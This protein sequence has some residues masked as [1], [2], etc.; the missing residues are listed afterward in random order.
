[1]WLSWQDQAACSHECSSCQYVS[2]LQLHAQLLTLLALPP[3]PP[4]RCSHVIWQTPRLTWPL[5]A[6]PWATTRCMTWWRWTAAQQVGGRMVDE[7]RCC[8]KTSLA[9]GLRAAG[10]WTRQAGR[11]A[12]AP[13]SPT[14]PAAAI[15][16]SS[17]SHLPSYKPL[18]ILPESRVSCTYDTTIRRSL[19]LLLTAH[20]PHPA[21]VSSSPWTPA[22]AACSPPT[23]PWTSPTCA[24][25]A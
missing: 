5:A 15:T 23:A 21:Q 25:A 14:C 1:M 7:D 18:L 16:R 22:R 3:L 8:C 13:P 6:P 10:C 24:P 11:Q 4:C 17:G 2:L 19:H 9:C 12:A 20:T